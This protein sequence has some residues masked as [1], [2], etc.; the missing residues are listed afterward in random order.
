M[1]KEKVFDYNRFMTADNFC[2][3]AKKAANAYLAYQKQLKEVQAYTADLTKVITQNE[4]NF[5]S[6]TKNKIQSEAYSL[7]RT[8]EKIP[9]ILGLIVYIIGIIIGCASV[10]YMDI[11]YFWPSLFFVGL[12]IFRLTGF[13]ED[14][15]S[16]SKIINVVVSVIAIIADCFVANDLRFF[17]AMAKKD[18][19]IEFIFAA[20]CIASRILADIVPLIR[21]ALYVL[22][23]KNKNKNIISTREYIE[24]L[25]K[26]RELDRRI[27]KGA[28]NKAKTHLEKLVN[29]NT[30]EKINYDYYKD[31]CQMMLHH[32][33]S[34][35][36]YDFTKPDLYQSDYDT[37]IAVIKKCKDSHI[38][39]IAL[40][41]QNEH[42]PENLFIQALYSY[43]AERDS[44]HRTVE[45]IMD[46]FNRL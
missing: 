8:K 13:Y 28:Q 29:G 37:M 12:C 23:I 1:E 21:K 38:I 39:D 25:E 40:G 20:F 19:S 10:E 7:Y 27:T 36:G 46:K 9:V 4:D 22:Y 24:G 18:T 42:H 3:E 41:E 15:D 6:K 32:I 5:I 33:K 14:L 11:S 30:V 44:M 2:K 26:A 16:I 35:Q 43:N 17:E 45:D 31:F 34:S